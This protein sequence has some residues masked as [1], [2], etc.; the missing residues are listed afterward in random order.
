MNIFNNMDAG[1][2][3]GELLPSLT[4]KQG[5]QKPDESSVPFKDMLKGLVDQVDTL[6]KEADASIQGLAT[7]ET[8]NVHDVVLKMEEAGIAFDLMMK[9]RDKLLEA[10]QQVIKM[11]Q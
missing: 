5:F 8:Q 10:Y 11:Q 2:P 1:L 9:V 3:D 4:E 7:G 6:Q